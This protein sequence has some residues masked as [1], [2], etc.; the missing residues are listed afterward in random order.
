V[1]QLNHSVPLQKKDTDLTE[2]FEHVT[3]YIT[4]VLDKEATAIIYDETVH[5]KNCSAR[6]PPNQ[7]ILVQPTV[8]LWQVQG[9]GGNTRPEKSR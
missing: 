5:A 2:R 4:L 3:E 6:T 7:S 9:S 8:I 1:A